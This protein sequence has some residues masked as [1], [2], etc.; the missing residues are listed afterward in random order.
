M[1]PV[2]VPRAELR[3]ASVA[4]KGRELAPLRFVAHGELHFVAEVTGGSYVLRRADSGSRV[5]RHQHRW[6]ALW[7]PIDSPDI[8]EL[9]LEKRRTWAKGAAEAHYE[10]T[11]RA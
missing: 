4:E 10:R 1:L 3:T 11:H 8:K 5:K 7:C 2:A 9:A 6:V